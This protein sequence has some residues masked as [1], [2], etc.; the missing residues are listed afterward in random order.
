MRL[1]PLALNPGGSVNT[2]LN[3]APAG[4]VVTLFLNGLGAAASP[5]VTASSGTVV[6]VSALQVSSVWQAN[7]QIPANSPAGGI[8]MSLT[9]G[10]VP[11]RDANLVVWVQ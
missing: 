10:G 2:C 5:V 7:I 9:A 11:V 1:L 8:Q 4:S 6:S 3:P